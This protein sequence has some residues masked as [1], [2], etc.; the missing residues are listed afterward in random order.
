MVVFF[1]PPAFPV[2]LFIFATGLLLLG[3]LIGW[4]WGCA[5]M[6]AALAARNQTLLLSQTER[7]QRT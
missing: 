7:V 2:Q 4:A 6:S 1:V 5:A 3:G